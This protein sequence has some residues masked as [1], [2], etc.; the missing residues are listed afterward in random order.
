MIKIYGAL[1]FVL[2]S[3]IVLSQDYQAEFQQYC[4]TNDTLGQ[5]KV[6]KKWQSESPKDAELFTNYFNY[7][8]T[9]SR[10][11]LVS[12]TTTPPNGESYM[13]KD[14][15]NQT[16]G[17]IGSQI[18]YNQSELKKGLDKIDEGIILYPNRLDM[19]FGKIYVFGQISD[20]K[21]FTSEIIKTIE[22]S[23][24]NQNSWSW[25]NNEKYAGGEKEFLLDIQNYQLQ[26]Y[27]TGND[28]LLKNMREIASSVLKFYPNHIESLSNLS[29]TYLLTGEFDKGIKPLLRAEKINPKDFIVLG[30]IAQGYKLKGDKKKAIEY[31][32]KTAKYGDERAREYARQQIRELKE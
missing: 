6:L 2:I 25:T 16:A 21:S 7:Y 30:N 22:H 28:N 3:Q 15:T 13:L 18:N 27:D 23:S 9:K 29:I 11:E 32:E 19:R 12:L 31:Y 1:V 5:L 26:L 4:E 24:K 10:Q 14:S 17:Y 8:F 20:W